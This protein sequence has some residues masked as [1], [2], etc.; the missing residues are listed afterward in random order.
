MIH[1]HNLRFYNLYFLFTQPIQLIHETI[2]PRIRGL[3]L[4]LQGLFLL[5]RARTLLARN[6]Y[7]HV[8]FWRLHKDIS[9]HDLVRPK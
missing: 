4:P 8:K 6:V 2:N 7:P 9:L 1:V 5:R 3:D